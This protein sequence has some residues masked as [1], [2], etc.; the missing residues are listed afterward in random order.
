MQATWTTRDGRRV[1][2]GYMSTSHVRN[3]LRMILSGRMPQGRVR[4]GLRIGEWA[5][6]F[7]SELR[8]R[9]Q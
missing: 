9:G 2:L 3:A 1:P 7:N 6:V 5:L 8:R 4:D